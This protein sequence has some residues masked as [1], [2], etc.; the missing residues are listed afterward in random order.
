MEVK[1]QHRPAALPPGKKPHTPLQGLWACVD[2]LE[3]RQISFPAG[4]QTP[5]PLLHNTDSVLKLIPVQFCP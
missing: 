2:G 4:I 1:G 3:E 5:D